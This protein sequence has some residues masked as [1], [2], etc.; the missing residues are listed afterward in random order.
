[1]PVTGGG[2]WSYSL[3]PNSGLPYIP[4]GNPGPDFSIAVR[5]GESLFTDSIVVLDARTGAYKS[6]VK[7][8]PCGQPTV[9]SSNERLTSRQKRALMGAAQQRV[10][11]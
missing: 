7:L 8:V 3:D 10:R 11:G 2:A 6:H 1:V 4:T 5:E 9:E